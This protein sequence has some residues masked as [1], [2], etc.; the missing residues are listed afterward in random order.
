MEIIFGTFLFSVSCQRL[1]CDLCS[2]LTFQ[3]TSVNNDQPLGLLLLKTMGYRL[4]DCQKCLLLRI[5]YSQVWECKPQGSAKTSVHI[6]WTCCAYQLGTAC[7]SMFRKKWDSP[8][9]CFQNTFCTQIVFLYNSHF[10]LL[11]YIPL[12]LYMA[13][14]H[15]IIKPN[16]INIMVSQPNQTNVVSK[17]DL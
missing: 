17:S 7:S 4:Y 2:K 13:N 16:K 12:I 10:I 3:K 5:I 14:I 15:H 8:T 11:Y 1:H 9:C 6:S